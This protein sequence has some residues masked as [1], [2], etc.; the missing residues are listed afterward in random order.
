MPQP[1]KHQPPKPWPAP[2]PDLV[3]GQELSVLGCGAA[4]PTFI[5]LPQ[6]GRVTMG[7]GN[8]ARTVD[9]KH[10]IAMGKT[11]VTVAQWKHFMA[12]SGYQLPA[13]KTTH[14]GWQKEAVSDQHPVRC[15]SAE[16]ADAYAVWFQ[17]KYAAQVHVAVRYLGLPSSDEGEYAARAGRWTQDRQWDE[18]K[19][20]CNLAASSNCT[21][22]TPDPVAKKGRSPNAW[23]LYDTIGNVQEWTSSTNP[24]FG[25]SRVV[26]GGNFSSNGNALR[27]SAGYLYPPGW[28]SIGGGFRVLARIEP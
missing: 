21:G 8:E 10:R 6:A 2:K 1:S 9:F 17:K 7:T 16:D 18:G 23:G 27:L 22:S 26:R 24:G 19:W 12:D 15:V 3:D 5:V 11:E 4:C 28:R 13:N 14:C 25:L 20:S